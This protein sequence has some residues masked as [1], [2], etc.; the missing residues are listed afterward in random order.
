MSPRATG[1]SLGWPDSNFLFSE[2]L[3]RWSCSARA[4][5]VGWGC[6]WWPALVQ[7]LSQRLWKAQGLQGQSSTVV[8]GQEPLWKDSVVPWTPLSSCWELQ[9][10]LEGARDCRVGVSPSPHRC[11]AKSNLLK[12]SSKEMRA[13]RWG[14]ENHCFMQL[15]S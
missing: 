3:W 8:S 13:E 6:L 1:G 14:Q 7:S 12:S 9:E 15:K 11:Q 10:L 5:G 4:G 2:G